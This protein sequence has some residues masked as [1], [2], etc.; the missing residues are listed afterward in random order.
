M[1]LMYAKE[2]IIMTTIKDIEENQRRVQDV[3]LQGSTVWKGKSVVLTTTLAEALY[4]NT[5]L[6]SLN[7]CDCGLNDA[8]ITKLTETLAHN[9][10]IFHLNLSNNK[11]ISRPG[12]IALGD[13]VATN[14]GLLTLELTGVRILT[15]VCAKFM[16]AYSNN[17]TLCKLV[18]DPEVSGY[19]LKFTELMN[20]NAEIDRA[21]RE[22]KPFDQFLP[23]GTTPPDLKPRI[24]P[25]PDEDEYGLE[26]GEDDP[27][28]WCQIAGRWELGKV[29]GRRGVGQRR[30]LVVTVEDVEHEIDPKSATQFEPSHAQN[31]PNMVMMGNL[32][33]VRLPYPATASLRGVSLR[34]KTPAPGPASSTC[35]AARGHTAE[36]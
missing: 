32:H 22:G 3:N 11:N 1:S 7:L 9:A 31:L 28:V 19:N 14:T 35:C 27:M 24:V 30:K 16:E 26:L 2:S 25:D 12:L 18:W 5:K 33:E 21:V 17:Y 20:R 29:E 36:P 13:A 6:T 23:K 10:T 8:A 15:E 34:V 4:N